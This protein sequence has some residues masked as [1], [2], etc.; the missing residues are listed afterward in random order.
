MSQHSVAEELAQCLL[1][2][3]EWRGHPRLLACAGYRL[4]LKVRSP[5]NI[6]I[7]ERC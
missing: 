7:A 1:A 6:E 5:R 3:H 2:I 4:S